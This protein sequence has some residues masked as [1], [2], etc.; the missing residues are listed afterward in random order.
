MRY[1]K[2]PN[3]RASTESLFL[4][5]NW[6]FAIPFGVFR[7]SSLGLSSSFAVQP[8]V[9][10]ILIDCRLHSSSNMTS[11]NNNN[12]K[13]TNKENMLL[14]N[15]HEEQQQ[16]HQRNS[17][18]TVKPDDIQLQL[19]ALLA[20]NASLRSQLQSSR[21]QNH[22]LLTS[23][24]RLHRAKQHIVH[25]LRYDEAGLLA[26]LA[27]ARQ[28]SQYLTNQNQELLANYHQVTT[29]RDT[30]KNNLVQTTQTAKEY[31]ATIG[32]LR[33]QLAGLSKIGTAERKLLALYRELGHHTG[34]HKWGKAI[35]V[36]E[37]ALVEAENDGEAA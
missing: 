32:Q 19:E 2:Q 33:E 23:N 36:A 12:N 29:D 37:A 8:L 34:Y 7:L 18:T 6:Q 28:E 17:P 35:R 3:E 30:I 31:H 4:S 24:A 20:E 13:K 11:N 10:L 21:H 26:S 5:Q 9:F 25:N 16:L 14:R 22:Y 15:L 27:E 1:G